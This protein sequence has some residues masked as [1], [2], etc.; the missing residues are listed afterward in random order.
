MDISI[1]KYTEMP[2]HTHKYYKSEVY[3]LH[4]EF[5]KT[6]QK[7]G[8]GEKSNFLLIE[9]YQYLFGPLKGFVQIFC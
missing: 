7:V 8:C 3:S 2:V 5:K 4:Q 6:V 1:N 9:M